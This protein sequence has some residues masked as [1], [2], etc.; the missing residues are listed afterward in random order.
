MAGVDLGGTAINYTL[1]QQEKSIEACSSI[2]IGQA[3]FDICLQQI[4]DVWKL[5]AEKVGVVLDD[6]V[7]AGLD[8][9]V[10]PVPRA[11][12]APGSTNFVHATGQDT[13]SATAWPANSAN[14]SPF[15]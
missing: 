7:A 13:T 11:N 4:A 8:T 2:R 6:A 5:A 14:R 10:P 15:K 9:P 12:S 3:G 1:D